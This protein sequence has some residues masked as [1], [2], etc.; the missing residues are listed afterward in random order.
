M[1]LLY[2]KQGPYKSNFTFIF[3]IREI[4]LKEDDGMKGRIYNA[5][6]TWQINYR[7]FMPK[8]LL[9]SGILIRRLERKSSRFIEF[10]QGHSYIK[11]GVLVGLLL[12]LLLGNPLDISLGK[13]ISKQEFF[14]YHLQDIA[15]HVLGATAS[16][17]T[18]YYLA[19][20]SYEGQLEGELFGIGEGKNLILIQMESMQNMVVQKEY[21]GQELTP[22]LNQLIKDPG[23]YYFDNFYCQ[24]G[25][26]NTSDAEFAV[27]HSLFGSIE[28][29]TYQLFEN[30]YFHGLPKIM[31]E[32]GYS[33]SVFHGYD[34]SFWNRENIYPKLGFDTYYSGE[35]FLSDEID[36]IGG[37]NIVGISDQAFYHQSIEKMKNLST[38]FYSFLI[39]LSTHNPFGLPEYLRGIELQAQDDNIFGDY[40]NSVHYADNSLGVFF[41]ELKE[42]GIYEDSIIILYGDHFGMTKAD[43][44]LSS[45]LSDWLGKEYTYD[46]MNRVPMIVHIPGH[47]GSGTYSLSGGQLDLFP[48]ISYLMGVE[49][50]NT[51][52]LGQNLFTASNGFVP[53]QMHMLK[54]S[55]IMD[56]VVFEMSRDGIFKH[57]KAWNRNTLE[58]LDIENY[59]E[60]YKVAKQSVELSEFYLNNDVARHVFL[61]GK[62][63]S[64]LFEEENKS[65][66]LPKSMTLF[67]YYDNS[68]SELTSMVKW[69]RNN[70]KEVLAVE[71][72]D[73]YNTLKSFET[74][75]FG[76]KGG[77]GSIMYVD[78]VENQEFMDMKSRIVPVL[79][80]STDDYVKLEYLGYHSILINPEATCTMDSVL[81]T[82]IET[83]KVGGLIVDEKK[84]SDYRYLQKDYEIQ[85][86]IKENN[87]LTKR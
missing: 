4:L 28:A 21:R 56:D 50:L 8:A 52:Y 81:E 77:P 85:L 34:K 37:G 82:F 19:T 75:Y 22:V 68:E 43:T 64:S 47:E 30:N 12:L 61:E 16:T 5:L 71:S 1:R 10:S 84:Y 29:Y 15:S 76:K 45:L 13:S 86:Y 24:I 42:S 17:E 2:Y 39:S 9:R 14:L 55:F 11:R 69:L 59:E 80:E 31:R 46:E 66:S 73:L 6:R 51:L 62:S 60:E 23:S 35:D 44:N 25:A 57:S 36:E 70:P 3:G 40:L 18:G 26:G 87:K 20:D 65:V 74:K 53:I 27:N 63:L 48:T 32:K 54:G 79:M 49:E 41:E 7:I 72:E 38:P 67:S 83:N 58:L 33:T 78:E